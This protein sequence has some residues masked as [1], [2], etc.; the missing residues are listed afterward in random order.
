MEPAAARRPS[1]YLFDREIEIGI[2]VGLVLDVEM[3]PFSIDRIEAAG[4][5]GLPEKLAVLFLLIGEILEV[6]VGALV[7]EVEYRAHVELLVGPYVDYGKIDGGAATVEGAPC[8]IAELEHHLLLDVGI[9]DRLS[10]LIGDVLA[11]GAEIVDGA[12]RTVGIVELEDV[13]HR[14]EDVGGLFAA[15]GDLLAAYDE[16]L[17]IAVYHFPEDILAA[18]ILGVNDAVFDNFVDIDPSFWQS[19][20]RDTNG[21]KIHNSL[22][23]I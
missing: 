2:G 9:V 20:L 3:P 13:A 17:E 19:L 11:P 23:G 1:L 15:L 22:L 7:H 4:Y 18:G 10:A 8:D 12:L 14:A 5:H 21:R 16:R 6:G